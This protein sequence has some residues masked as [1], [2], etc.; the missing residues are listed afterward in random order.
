ME[1]D[2]SSR[3]HYLNDDIEETGIADVLKTLDERS[4]LE[5]LDRFSL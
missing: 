2:A 1:S 5:M 4:P 3:F